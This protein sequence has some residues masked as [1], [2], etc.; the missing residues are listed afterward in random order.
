MVEMLRRTTEFDAI[1]G[2]SSQ[3]SDVCFAYISVYL[4]K[5][6]DLNSYDGHASPSKS[7]PRYVPSCHNVV[8][9]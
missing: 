3:L 6:I 7:S 9:I 1:L 2:S 5:P 4:R 8:Y